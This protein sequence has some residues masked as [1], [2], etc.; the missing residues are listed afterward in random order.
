MFGSLRR[1]FFF[2]TIAWILSA[3]PAAAAGVE[4]AFVTGVQADAFPQVTVSFRALDSDGRIPGQLTKQDIDIYENGELVNE[5]DEGVNFQLSAPTVAPVYVYFVVDVGRYADFNSFGEELIRQS[6]NHFVSGGFFRD[7]VDTVAILA[8]RGTG[9][10]E[11]RTETVLP[12]TTSAAAFLREVERFSLSSSPDTSRDTRGLLGVESALTGLDRL[13]DPGHTSAAVIYVGRLI[14]RASQSTPITDAQNL[15][16]DAREQRVQLYTF[17]AE[18][19]D[20]RA[21]D[22]L[23]VLQAL[24]GQTGGEYLRLARNRDQSADFDRIYGDIKTQGTSYQATFRSRVDESGQRRVAI[25]PQ[26]ATADAAGEV[27]EYNVALQPATVAIT[28]PG[29]NATY[30][31]RGTFD[32]SEIVV[33]AELRDWPDRIPRLIDRVELQDGETGASLLPPIP[34]PP[35]D[36]PFE[37]RLDISDLEE[38][39]DLVLKVVVY[40]ELGIEASAS[41]R[42]AIRVIPFTPTPIVVTRPVEVPGPTVLIENPCDVNPR[43]QECIIYNVRTYAPWGVVAI[44]G[45][46]LFFTRRQVGRLASAA[47][48]AVKEGVAEV[49]KTILGGAGARGKVL[50]KLHVEVARKDLVGV[51]IEIKSNRT[52][53]GRNPKLSDVS[54]Y[55]EDDISTVSGDHCTIQFDKRLGKFFIT[56]NNSTAGTEVNSVLLEPNQ[57]RELNTDDVIVLGDLYRR[58]AKVRFEIVEAA[59]VAGEVPPETLLA[60]EN[61]GYPSQPTPGGETILGTETQPTEVWDGRLSPPGVSTETEN[62]DIWNAPPVPPKSS[63]DWMDDLS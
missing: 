3:R 42:V 43:S 44:L 25:V 15:S 46:V 34:N 36:E 53:L 49:R 56:D 24:V 21:Q 1:V 59:A 6:M 7:G 37:F 38:S 29:D 61:M 9:G 40:D 39:Q 17:H 55:D 41:V 11:D 32:V 50:A 23:G 4:T 60:G 54:L 16:G 22:N 13:T 5:N 14:E 12:P 10:S 51:T 33:A 52:T 27:G 57:P 2:L 28:S 30:E 47:G 45:V 58:G 35:A 63:D 26:G 8:Q 20:D 19:F 18:Q 48:A 62:T 31:R